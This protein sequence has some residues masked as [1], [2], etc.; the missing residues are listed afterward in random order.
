VSNSAAIHKIQSVLN[1]VGVALSALPLSRI[2]Y[3]LVL[4]IVFLILNVLA[5][6]FWKLMPLP[7]VN[8]TPQSPMSALSVSSM[9]MI[10]KPS[11][12]LATLQS[13][14]L[15]GRTDGKSVEQQQPSLDDPNSAAAT[16]LNLVLLGILMSDDPEGSFAVIE[17][18]QISSLY[19]VGDEIPIAQGVKLAKVLVD[20]VIINNR[21]SM[22]ALMLYDDSKP[23]IGVVNNAGQNV[24]IDQRRNPEISSMA[25][26]YRNQL[27]TNPMSMTDVIKVSI[28]KGPDG[29]VIGYRIR[30]GRDREQFAKFG[31]QA[32]DVVTAINGVA[33]DDPA[34]AMELYGQLRD[35][36]EAS[37]VVKR[38]NQEVNLIVGLNQ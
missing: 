15:F 34:K 32:G 27:L 37:F 4:L 36:Q 11:V 17:G 12:D 14:S 18:G 24:V 33:L 26:N 20:R 6:I 25:S 21:G 9:P 7:E 3:F 22:E 30:P 23:A 1:Q 31:L 10:S 8:S 16:S 38:G 19:K 2:R 28:A 13:W 35:A 5:D 29:S